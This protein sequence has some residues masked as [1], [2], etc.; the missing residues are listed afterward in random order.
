MEV[1]GDVLDLDLDTGPGDEGLDGGLELGLELG[2]EACLE[3]DPRY[4][5]SK[6]W[7]NALLVEFGDACGEDTLEAGLEVDLEPL[8]ELLLEPRY[9]FSKYEVKALL[10]EFGDEGLEVDLEPDFK[11]NPLVFDSNCWTRI[12]L[13]VLGEV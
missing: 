12:F 5:F 7:V 13:W 8:L 6:N 2:L 1:I 4:P 3:L 11:L 10:S 9:P